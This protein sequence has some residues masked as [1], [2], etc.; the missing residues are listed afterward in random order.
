SGPNSAS[1]SEN[2]V[3]PKVSLSYRLNDGQMI[4]STIAKG[5]RTGGANYPNGSACDSD[6]AGLGLSETPEGYDSD[7]LWSYELGAKTTWLD[8]RMLLNA[9][10]YYNDWSDIQQSV[11]LP[12]CFQGFVANVGKA[13]SQ[14][15]EIELAAVPTER[16][17]LGFSVSYT[18]A[19]F[20]E[21]NAGV[22]ISKGDPVQ[23]ISDWKV[24]LNG[25]YSFP[26]SDN[27]MGYFAADFQYLSD[28]PFGFNF[29]QP[30]INTKDAYSMLGLQL[31]VNRANWELFLFVNNAL[32]ES[33][34]L[35]VRNFGAAVGSSDLQ[36]NTLRPRTI[37][38]TL[39]TSFN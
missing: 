2:G 10:V 37:G 32:N 14:G 24:N 34:A 28:A 18:D 6:L 23:I 26:V 35:A 20:D 3:N 8:N 25:Q 21:D 11:L 22:G 27:L 38:L 15:F 5:Y 13:H 12:T 33:P 4:Y 17:E 29:D 16:L 31:G 9:A 1:N 7:S 39:R 30:E 36:I 19:E